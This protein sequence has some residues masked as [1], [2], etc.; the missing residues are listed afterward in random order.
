MF[1]RILKCKNEKRPFVQ[2]VL[3]VAQMTRVTSNTIS[4]AKKGTSKDY[5]IDLCDDDDFE[6]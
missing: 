5:A 2:N 6:S 4:S 3:P 1:S